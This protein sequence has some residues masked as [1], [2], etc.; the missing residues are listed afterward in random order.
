MVYGGVAS[1]Q[2]DGTSNYTV[3]AEQ[4]QHTDEKRRIAQKAATLI[5]PGDVV[6][7]DSGTTVQYLAE[8]LPPEDSYTFICY[9]LNTINVIAKR[10][11]GALIA[12]GG[13]FSEKSLVFSG[14]VAVS[15]MRKYRANKAFIGATGYEI[16]HGLTCAFVED[17]ALKE[18]AIEASVQ[19]ILLIDSS[20]FGLVSTCSFADLDSFNCVIT[21]SGISSQYM[22]H[23]KAR[24][25]EVVTV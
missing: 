9:S 1:L 7:L 17:S 6:F 2:K 18:A 12:P 3:D 15:A 20:K 13:V 4:G 22:T 5:E 24:V 11:S 10:P 14:P 19:R 16:K 21:D 23:L 8:C 25:P